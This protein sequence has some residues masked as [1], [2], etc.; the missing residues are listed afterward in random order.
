MLSQRLRLGNRPLRFALGDIITPLNALYGYLALLGFY[1]LWLFA[2]VPY[3]GHSF[4]GVYARPMT[5]GIWLLLAVCLLHL[6]VQRRQRLQGR[7]AAPYLGLGV[8][9][10]LVAL[11]LLL[12][13]GRGALSQTPY[14]NNYQ[15]GMLVLFFATA[16]VAFAVPS[17]KDGARLV[18]IIA[19]FLTILVFAEFASILNRFLGVVQIK[20]QTLEFQYVI[21]FVTIYWFI[22]YLTSKGGI[23]KNG[24]ILGVVV[25]GAIG[26]L[27]KPVVVPLFFALLFVGFVFLVAY[28]R[29]PALRSLTIIKRALLLMALVAAAVILLEIIIPSSFLGDYRLIFYDRFLKVDPFTGVSE[30]RIDGGRL[31]Y[32]SL[33]WDLVKANPLFG[34]GLGAAFPHPYISGRFSFPHSIILDFLLSYGIIGVLALFAGIIL[35]TIFLLLNL[36]MGEFTLE[37]ATLCGYLF[38]AFLVSLVSYFWGHLPLVHATAISLGIILKMAILDARS[39]APTARR[40][41][42]RGYAKAR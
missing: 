8:L 27:Q 32:Y 15:Q 10:L 20:S 19:Y 1:G 30:G 18:T 4:L 41:R 6:G 24:I 2:V 35:M 42:L 3:F 9:M 37:K 7:G 16:A 40:I 11:G 34:L 29:H 14:L 21:P 31:E 39:I 5:L 25:F 36:R 28:Y 13:I 17:Q 26:R 22:R 23:L 12:G 38:Y 33:A